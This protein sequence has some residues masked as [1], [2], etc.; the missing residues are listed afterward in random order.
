MIFNIQRESFINS[1]IDRQMIYGVKF[2]CAAN[3]SIIGKQ[4]KAVVIQ[5][6]R[7]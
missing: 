3:D 7:I 6:R 1:S 4:C 5:K 2:D